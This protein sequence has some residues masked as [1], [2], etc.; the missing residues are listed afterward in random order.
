MHYCWSQLKSPALSSRAWSQPAPLPLCRS[1]FLA[2]RPDAHQVEA[3]QKK[4]EGFV[5]KADERQRAIEAALTMLVRRLAP[6]NAEGL[7]SMMGSIDMA[8]Q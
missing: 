5:A 3:S 1:A 4:V 6:D 2:V 7:S 8:P